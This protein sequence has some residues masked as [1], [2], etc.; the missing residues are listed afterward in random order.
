MNPISDGT[1]IDLVQSLTAHYG[2]VPR[3][4]MSDAGCR[5]FSNP[6]AM[7]GSGAYIFI[8]KGRRSGQVR[9]GASKTGSSAIS[10]RMIAEIVARR[11]R[12]PCSPTPV[13]G[14]PEAP[15]CPPDGV[16]APSA[17]ST[18]AL[19]RRAAGGGAVRNIDKGY[20]R[21]PF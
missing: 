15:S 9:Y 5:A 18:A 11:L 7:T 6:W 1:L 4:E 17:G 14:A 10:D 16:S 3:P 20:L 19:A 13:L 8:L 21:G 2:A 12:A